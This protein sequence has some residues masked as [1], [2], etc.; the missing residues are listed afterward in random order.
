[1]LEGL[2][3]GGLTVGIERLH[4]L[5]A[6]AMGDERNLLEWLGTPQDIRDLFTATGLDPKRLRAL[7]DFL[8]VFHDQQSLLL[9]C[10][11]ARVRQAIRDVADGKGNIATAVESLRGTVNLRPVASPKTDD[12]SPDGPTRL[13]TDRAPEEEGHAPG[14]EAA[15]AFV[16]GALHVPAFGP[17]VALGPQ[18]ILEGLRRLFGKQRVEMQPEPSRPVDV[19]LDDVARV[20]EAKGLHVTGKV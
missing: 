20:V 10:D 7:E 9:T 17:F 2:R 14:E 13:K 1:M 19:M 18:V 12:P 6:I 16:V 11:P 15:R 5:A 4:Q 3:Q 8:A